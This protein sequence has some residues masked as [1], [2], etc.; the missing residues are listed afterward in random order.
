MN[1]IQSLVSI[2]S[3]EMKFSLDKI[4]NLILLGLFSSTN[5]Y[6]LNTN[7]IIEKNLPNFLLKITTFTF[8]SKI[9][10]NSLKKNYTSYVIISLS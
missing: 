9:F 7:L 2:I 10:F 3:K 5:L 1:K 6:N 8:L 4:K